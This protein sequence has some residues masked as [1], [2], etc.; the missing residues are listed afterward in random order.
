MNKFVRFAPLPSTGSAV[1]HSAQRIPA[2]TGR[3]PA[4]C[5]SVSSLDRSLTARAYR[6][7]LCGAR[8]L[9]PVLHIR[10][11]VPGLVLAGHDV[12]GPGVPASFMSSL[13]AAAQ[14]DPGLW[15]AF[16]R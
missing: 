12:F 3:R 16:R 6:L 13:I 11:P 2:L 7:E 10:T 14:V 1:I 9:R 4:S 15:A 8:Q 5:R